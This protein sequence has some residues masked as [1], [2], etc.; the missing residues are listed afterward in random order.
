MAIH[1]LRNPMSGEEWAIFKKE[2][3]N[4]ALFIGSKA[5]R[6]LRRV[7]K[8]HEPVF[9]PA[10]IERHARIGIEKAFKLFDP[11]RHTGLGI[12][13]DEQVF[14][15]L[16]VEYD[17]IKKNP[18]SVECFSN[19]SRKFRVF[20]RG[21]RSLHVQNGELYKKIAKLIRKR[22]T[23]RQ[24]AIF[25]VLMKQPRKNYAQIGS[26]LKLSPSMITVEAKIIYK[27]A[28]NSLKQVRGL[29]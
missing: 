10:I 24:Y 16:Q 7:L 3:L 17:R 19:K 27:I 8:R 11:T 1:P 18:L 28:L 20:M 2:T 12:I 26:M 14:N 4:N 9:V 22:L 13:I 23:R 6:K 29:L 25:T 15:A 5:E 21:M